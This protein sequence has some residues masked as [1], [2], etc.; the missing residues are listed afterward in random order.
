MT[1]ADP[2]RRRTGGRPSGQLSHTRGALAGTVRGDATGLPNGTRKSLRTYAP[3]ALSGDVGA[4]GLFQDYAPISQAAASTLLPTAGVFEAA[5]LLL[6]VALMPLLR[7]VT[8]RLRR[9]VEELQHRALYDQLTGLPNRSL[10]RDR[11]EQAILTVRRES[12]NAT[13]MFLDIDHFKEINDT[14]GHEAGDLLLKALAD[15]LRDQMRANET[16]ARL[17]GNEFGIL[18]TGI[19][20]DAVVLAERLHAALQEPF[21]VCELPLEIALS[22]R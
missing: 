4:V 12:G 13:V 8:L 16:L 3:V 11:A 18:C 20:S 9:Q 17:G 5:L 19:A 21:V 1:T 22:V 14:L 7:R 15:R 2:P 6:F 10:F